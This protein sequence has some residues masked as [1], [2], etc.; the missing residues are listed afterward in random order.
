MIAIS[1]MLGFAAELLVIVF[2]V[3]TSPDPPR[4]LGPY[5]AWGWLQQPGD[6]FDDRQILPGGLLE[7]FVVQ[8]LIYS[9]VAYVTTRAFRGWREGP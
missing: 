5:K 6:Y 1:F 7:I 3:L 8:G 2:N 4:W 9:G